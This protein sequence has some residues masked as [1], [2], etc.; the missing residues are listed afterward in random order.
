MKFV[1]NFKIYFLIFNLIF[2]IDPIYAQPP[3][4][5]E[6]T[7]GDSHVIFLSRCHMSEFSI[8]SS[9]TQMNFSSRS[10]W[11]E[12]KHFPERESYKLQN[13]AQ[14]EEYNSTS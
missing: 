12:V 6:K 9:Y 7:K 14:H 11:E 10:L 4:G 1:Y 5:N 13:D 8:S 3:S 2:W